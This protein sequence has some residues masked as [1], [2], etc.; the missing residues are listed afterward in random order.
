MSIKDICT[1]FG[2]SKRTLTDI[3]LGRIYKEDDEIYPIRD[4]NYN[5][6]KFSN[7]Q[8]SEIINLLAS[9]NLSMSEIG[10]QFNTFTSTISYINKG[11]IYKRDNIKYPIR[12]K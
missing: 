5:I 10:K 12:N 7:E 4:K 11:K 1:K 8:I 9:S 2:F 6:K 3:N